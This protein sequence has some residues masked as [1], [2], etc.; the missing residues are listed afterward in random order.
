L[1]TRPSEKLAALLR[2]EAE[3]LSQPLDVLPG[4]VLVPVGDGAEKGPHDALEIGN[5]HPAYS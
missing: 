2:R 5:A 4:A 3:L 1:K